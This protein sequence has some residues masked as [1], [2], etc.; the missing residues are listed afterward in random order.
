MMTDQMFAFLPY[1]PARPTNDVV[2]LKP[3]LVLLYLSCLSYKTFVKITGYLGRHTTWQHNN[4]N[5]NLTSQSLFYLSG[6]ARVFGCREWIALLG[7]CLLCVH[8]SFFVSESVL[9]RGLAAAQRGALRSTRG[10]TSRLRQAEAGRKRKT[11]TRIIIF[12][13]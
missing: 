13:S 3:R 4:N 8:I 6:N 2:L 9:V 7:C 11:W 10:F 1:L 12:Y 5:K